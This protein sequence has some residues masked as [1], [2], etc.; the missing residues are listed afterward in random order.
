MNNTIKIIIAGGIG[1]IVQKAFGLSGFSIAGFAVFMVLFVV[2]RILLDII[3]PQKEL[4]KLEKELLETKRIVRNKKIFNFF[5][6]VFFIIGGYLFLNSVINYIFLE[7]DI[8]YNKDFKPNYVTSKATIVSFKDKVITLHSNSTKYLTIIKKGDRY[9]LLETKKYPKRNKRYLTVYDNEVMKYDFYLIVSQLQNL[10]NSYEIL[11]NLQWTAYKEVTQFDI[12]TK[13]LWLVNPSLIHLSKWDKKSINSYLKD[14]KLKPFEDLQK[15]LRQEQKS[16][17]KD[18][19]SK[20]STMEL[21]KILD[22]LYRLSGF[23]YNTNYAIKVYKEFRSRGDKE[24]RQAQKKYPIWNTLYNLSKTVSIYENNK[25]LD[26]ILEKYDFALNYKFNYPILAQV[27]NIKCPLFSYIVI[28]DY[29]NGKETTIFTNEFAIKKVYNMFEGI[30]PKLDIELKNNQIIINRSFAK[31][32][33]LTL[34]QKDAKKAYEFL[35]KI[36]DS[37]MQQENLFYGKNNSAN[38]NY[39]KAKYLVVYDNDMQKLVYEY[40]DRKW[41]QIQKKLLDNKYAKYN[42]IMKYFRSFEV[43]VHNDLKLTKP[44][45]YMFF[46]YKLNKIYEDKKL[47]NFDIKDLVKLSVKDRDVVF[48]YKL[49]D[50]QSYL[51][52]SIMPRYTNIKIKNKKPYIFMAMSL[53]STKEINKKYYIYLTKQKLFRGGLPNQLYYLK[54]NDD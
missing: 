2:F 49:K 6:I 14:F 44:I 37:L 17:T 54:E 11:K 23:E 27:N 29:K 32:Y 50:K 48:V 5:Q 7:A 3:F 39:T 13:P 15:R 36:I 35:V 42:Y 22:K 41:T 47:D 9:Y 12:I 53:I 28:Y 16:I 25:K 38:F 45:K 34:N 52:Y 4:G 8:V 26:K 20:L 30:E 31:P 43:N 10:D 21:A 18:D 33:I 40:K 46:N 19:L 24:K 1:T 51:K